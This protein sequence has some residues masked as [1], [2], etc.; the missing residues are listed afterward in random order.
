VSVRVR[1]KKYKVESSEKGLILDLRSKNIATINEIEGLN[2]L[3][4]LKRLYIESNQITRIEGL[5]SLSHL[6]NLDLESNRIA[7][8]ERLD[9]IAQLQTFALGNNQITK[10][11]GL[12][13]LTNLRI[14]YLDSNR[15]TRMEGLE[16]LNNLQVLNLRNNQIT[17]IEG[18]EQLT[19]LQELDLV[20]N[21]I[22]KIEGLN[23]RVYLKLSNQNEK[24]YRLLF[25]TQKIKET[26][27][28]L[29]TRFPRLLVTEIAEECNIN[30]LQLIVKIIQDMI[31]NGQI[32]A[33]YFK[34]S[35]AV[36]FDQQANI[37]FAK[38][39]ENEFKKWE[40]EAI[41]KA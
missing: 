27:L 6:L 39:L 25:N 10:I 37:N 3:T 17:T 5:D 11:E 22:T 1:G 40:R 26:L 35:E 16:Q 12:N 36:A 29:G 20:D 9:Q 2:L 38:D 32:R 15:I 31:S 4:D 21:E 14:L 33:K 41:K 34:S 19:H 13:K 18:L 28:H 7:K 23:E 30:D 24:Q 8:I